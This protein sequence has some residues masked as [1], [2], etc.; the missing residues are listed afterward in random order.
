MKFKIRTADLGADIVFCVG[1]TPTLTLLVINTRPVADIN[2]E[3]ARSVGSEIP[4]QRA[5][6]VAAT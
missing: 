5:A 4:S 1:Y 6:A 2:I 3:H